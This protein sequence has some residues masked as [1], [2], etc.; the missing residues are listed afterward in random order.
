MH[1]VSD[2]TAPSDL[3]VRL[4][5]ALTRLSRHLRYQADTGMTPTQLSALSAVHRAERLTLGEL[6]AAEGVRRPTMSRVAADLE[7]AGLIVRE[8]DPSDGR[9]AWLRLSPEGHR[10]IHRVHT[11]KDQYVARRLAALSAA[12]RATLDRAVPVLERLLEGA[13]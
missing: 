4:R 5:L 2:R 11:R 12:E 9:V 7:A 13:E 8:P 1:V 6:A 10:A 3:S